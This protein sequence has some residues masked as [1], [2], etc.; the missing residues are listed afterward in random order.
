MTSPCIR[1]CTL[2]PETGICVGCG[3][4]LA[5]IGKWASVTE[6]ERLAIMAVLP[7]RLARQRRAP[8]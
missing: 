7:D 2:D 3:R 1:H 4:T 6:E 8:Q 5:E